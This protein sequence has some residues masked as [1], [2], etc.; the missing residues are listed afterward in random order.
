[1]KFTYVFFSAALFTSSNAFTPIIKNTR[2]LSVDSGLN[3]KAGEKEGVVSKIKR[4]IKGKRQPTDPF[5]A[6]VKEI[7]PGAIDNNELQLKVVKTLSK[8]GYSEDNTLLATSLCCDELARQLEDDFLA[9]YGPN[10]NLGGLSGFPFAGNTGFGAMAAHI[11]GKIA[12]IILARIHFS[13]K[14]IIQMMDIAW[15]S[16]DLML[17]YRPMAL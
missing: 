6:K 12:V 7:F 2:V 17:E 3:V 14:Y 4:I 11:P 13:L 8:K 15:L 16:T 10:F 5:D 1:M 9:V